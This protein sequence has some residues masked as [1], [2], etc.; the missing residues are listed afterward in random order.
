VPLRRRKKSGTVPARRGEPAGEEGD[1]G[2]HPLSARSSGYQVVDDNGP[3]ESPGKRRQLA[4]GAKTEIAFID[5]ETKGEIE[6]GIGLAQWIPLFSAPD[7]QGAA[8]C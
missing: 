4:S 7:Y 5:L 3:T 8:C 2:P 6:T 1:R